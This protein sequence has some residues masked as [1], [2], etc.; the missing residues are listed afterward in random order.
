MNKKN[1]LDT[2]EEPTT[3]QLKL[4]Y[5]YAV[6]KDRNMRVSYATIQHISSLLFN[7]LFLYTTEICPCFLSSKY[8]EI[9]NVIY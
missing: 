8:L 2:C 6:V 9:Q 1:K 3:F 4:L 7:L 5:M